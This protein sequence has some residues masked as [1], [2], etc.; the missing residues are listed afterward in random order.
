[1]LKIAEVDKYAQ[2]MQPHRRKCKCGHTVII[3]PNLGK[4]LCSACGNYVFVSQKEEFAY[5]LK[6][7][8]NKRRTYERAASYR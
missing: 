4:K 1:M 2:A 8:M 5:R 3:A 7:Q 6:E